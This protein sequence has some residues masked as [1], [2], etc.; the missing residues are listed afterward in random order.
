MTITPADP[1][2]SQVQMNLMGIPSDYY[3]ALAPDPTDDQLETIRQTLR[4]LTGREAKEKGP[5]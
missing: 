5:S 4:E 2:S 1:D 3:L